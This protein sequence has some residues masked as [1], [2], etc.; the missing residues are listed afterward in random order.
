MPAASFRRAA[1]ALAALITLGAAPI[2][3][4]GHAGAAVADS[5][6][7]ITDASGDAVRGGAAAGEPKADIIAASARN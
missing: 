5:S 1:G 4:A 2:L 6:V 7:S 3:T